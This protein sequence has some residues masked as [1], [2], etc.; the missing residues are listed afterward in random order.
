MKPINSRSYLV[1]LGVAA[2]TVLSI[3]C[4]AVEEVGEGVE[5]A[6]DEIADEARDARR[7]R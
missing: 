7:R 1:L 4:A 3:G 2:F 6:G 5:D